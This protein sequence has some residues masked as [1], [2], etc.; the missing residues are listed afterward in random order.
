MKWNTNGN[1]NNVNSGRWTAIKLVRIKS[2][3]NVIDSTRFSKILLFVPIL[4]QICTHSP[5]ISD[6]N[7]ST[8]NLRCVSQSITNV[9]DFIQYLLDVGWSTLEMNALNV[10]DLFQ[11]ID[12]TFNVKFFFNVEKIQ[13]HSFALDVL[14]WERARDVRAGKKRCN[15]IWRMRGQKREEINKN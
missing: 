4:R 12:I 10:I 15:Y 8:T 14:K 11:L 1:K 3:K 7:C 2:A 9:S 5:H 13:F 6:K